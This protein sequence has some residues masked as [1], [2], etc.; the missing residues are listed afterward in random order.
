MQNKILLLML[1]MTFP[2]TSAAHW[3]VGYVEDAADATS[4]TEEPLNYTTQQI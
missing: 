3:I 1:L 2:L 4:P